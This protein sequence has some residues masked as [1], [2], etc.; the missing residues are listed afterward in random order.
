[1]MASAPACLAARAV[2]QTNPP[3]ATVQLSGD[4]HG[5]LK[6]TKTVTGQSAPP[7]DTNYTIA[8]DNGAGTSGTVVVQ[9]GKT[10]TVGNLPFGSYTLS[11][12]SPPAGDKVTISP[13]PVTVS[14]DTRTANI[15]VTNAFPDDGGFTVTKHVTGETGGYVAGSTFTVAYSCSNGAIRHADAGRRRHQGRD[16]PADRHDLHAVR[17]GQ[18]ADQGRQ[19][20]LRPGVVDPFQ[21]GDHRRQRP[22]TRSGSCLTNPL[23]RVAGWLHGDQARDGRDRRLCGRFDL[24]GVVLLLRRHDRAR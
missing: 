11:E 12:V 21:H 4:C 8:Y 24:H 7:A 23:T 1:M 20:R 3:S 17:D 6:I 5:N 9:A 22:T 13:N 18:A 19:L 15:S 16:H 10:V 14:P 2:M